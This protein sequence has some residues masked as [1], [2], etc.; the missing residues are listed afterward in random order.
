PNENADAVG[1]VDG[2]EFDVGPRRKHRMT[3][4]RGAEPIE[5]ITIGQRPEDDGLW[6]A[7][8]HH[9]DLQRLAAR[10]DRDAPEVARYAHV[11]AK[12]L[13]RAGAAGPSQPFG[14]G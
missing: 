14:T 1:R 3:F 7:E 10:L 6:I 12:Q 11:R 9:H 5:A 4:E 8:V 13:T 2:G